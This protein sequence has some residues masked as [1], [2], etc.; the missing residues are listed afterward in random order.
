MTV[1]NSRSQ[2]GVQDY[3][4]GA[5]GIGVIQYYEHSEDWACS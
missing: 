3:M 4:T 1:Q 5:A 2:E